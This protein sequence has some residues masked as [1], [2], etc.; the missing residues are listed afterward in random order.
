M[1]KGN[2]IRKK[3]LHKPY[4]LRDEVIQWKSIPLCES[5]FAK[6]HR[7]DRLTGADSIHSN[8]TEK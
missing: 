3:S 8:L 7:V 5:Y 4:R 2:R 6:I 1:R